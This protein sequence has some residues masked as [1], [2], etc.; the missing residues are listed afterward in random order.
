M[1]QTP[2]PF[3]VEIKRSRRPAASAA[4]MEFFGKD[5]SALNGGVS[6][7]LSKRDSFSNPASHSEFAVPCFLQ[8][9]KAAHRTSSDH[10]SREA[11]QVFGPKT[12]PA[13]AEPH[14]SEIRT[15]PRILPSLIPQAG[16]AQ[17]SRAESDAR[18][19]AARHARWVEAPAPKPRVAARIERVEK[20][21]SRAKRLAN[22]TALS[23]ATDIEKKRKQAATWSG[24]SSQKDAAAAP[25]LTAENATE[26]SAAH[27]CG[28]C[29][30]VRVRSLIRRSR[31]DAAA[32]PPGQHW[33]RRLN[34]RAW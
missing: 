9:D 1:K 5:S 25:A 31:A 3:A 6:G 30:G 27:A 17:D 8:T 20:I 10:F 12:A 7:V 16:A 24:A 19:R 2:K 23:G 22:D 13:A 33:K 18:P 32:L 14:A 11:A 21:E 34:P 4:P 15:Q 26:S 28:N 29:R